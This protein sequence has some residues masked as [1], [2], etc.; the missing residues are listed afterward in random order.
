MKTNVWSV[1]RNALIYWL[2]VL[3]ALIIDIFPEE[4]MNLTIGAAISMI[5]KFIVNKL[6]YGK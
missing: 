2:P 5:I 3:G 6:K 1:V 4:Y